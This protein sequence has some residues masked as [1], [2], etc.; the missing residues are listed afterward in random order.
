MKKNDQLSSVELQRILLA[1]CNNIT[2]SART[3]HC[4]FS[5]EHIFV[6]LIEGILNQN[7]LQPTRNFGVPLA[8]PQRFILHS[9]WVPV[10]HS[11]L[12]YFCPVLQHLEEFI[13]QRKEGNTYYSSQQ[14]AT[15]ITFVGVFRVTFLMPQVCFKPITWYIEM[16]HVRHFFLCGIM[17]FLYYVMFIHNVLFVCH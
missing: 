5:M 16:H 11:L 13:V 9:I 1:R 14:T 10:T 7:T 2:V 6:F 12:R 15:P 3:I 4:K 8:F 17:T